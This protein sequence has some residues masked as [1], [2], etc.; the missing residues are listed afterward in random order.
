MLHEILFALLGFH[1]DI[2][3]EIDNTYR[4]KDNFDLCREGEYEQINRIVPLGWYYVQFNNII[5]KYDISWYNISHSNNKNTQM[6]VYLIAMVQG[7]SDLLHEYTNDVAYL[8]QYILKD[9]PIP[10]SQVIQ[11]LQKVNTI[12]TILSIYIIFNNIYSI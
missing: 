1:G 10:L 6:K 7:I 9:G 2:I 5:Q 4:I 8:E 12:C 11:Q 3:I